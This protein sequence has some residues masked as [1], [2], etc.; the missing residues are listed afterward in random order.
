MFPYVEGPVHNAAKT[1]QRSAYIAVVR[2]DALLKII[3]VI[4]HG[5][6]AVLKDTLPLGWEPTSG[7]KLW[8]RL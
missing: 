3:A 2:Y 6:H 1:Y 7:S 5:A 4:K 8:L